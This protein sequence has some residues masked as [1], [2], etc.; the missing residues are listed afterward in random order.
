MNRQ[1]AFN[2]VVKELLRQ[3]RK[4]MV[5]KS[6]RYRGADGRKCAGGWL[7]PDHRY[8]ENIEGSCLNYEI[9]RRCISRAY[10]PVKH[11]DMGF[12]GNLQI[13]HDEH[14]VARWPTEFRAIARRYRLK[15]PP[16]LAR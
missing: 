9:A 1:K 16:E 5:G 3:G 15:L 11:E 6:C 13:V 8:S 14:S 7:I 10:G 4:S 2:K 12:I